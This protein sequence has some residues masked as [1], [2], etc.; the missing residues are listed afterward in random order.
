[1][2]KHVNSIVAEAMKGCL[3]NRD[4][5]RGVSDALQ[6]V[7]SDLTVS[8]DTNKSQIEELVDCWMNAIASVKV[9]RSSCL[10]VL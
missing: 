2:S 7:L 1:M 8:Q 6:S 5:L 4:V 9:T 3:Q 10:A